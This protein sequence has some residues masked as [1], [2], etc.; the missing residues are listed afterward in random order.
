MYTFPIYFLHMD[1]TLGFFFYISKI[2]FY[3]KEEI[4]RVTICGLTYSGRIYNLFFDPEDLQNLYKKNTK[5][6]L[7]GNHPLFFSFFDR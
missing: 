3:S 6:C 1:Q 4:D 7:P 2:Q 5:G